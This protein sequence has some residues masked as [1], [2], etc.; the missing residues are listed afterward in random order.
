[1]DRTKI[2]PGKP[3]GADLTLRRLRHPRSRQTVDRACQRHRRQRQ[4]ARHDDDGRRPFGS[5]LMAA[6]FILNN[7]L[8]DFSFEPGV[9]NRRFA[10]APKPASARSRR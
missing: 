5:H 10:N 3:K 1:M 6:G 7:Q 8:T 2:A 4:R 9:D